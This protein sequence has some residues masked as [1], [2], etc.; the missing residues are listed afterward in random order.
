MPW[1]GYRPIDP[2]AIGGSFSG[3][4][5]I[6]ICSRAAAGRQEL[7]SRQVGRKR[8]QSE[9]AL[10]YAHRERARTTAGEDQPM[11]PF[12]ASGGADSGCEPGAAIRGGMSMFRRKRT[13]E[14]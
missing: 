10:L 5:W 14:D 9:G 1:A 12:G 8:K 3:R 4:A 7:D 6:V 13:T 2:T 11:A